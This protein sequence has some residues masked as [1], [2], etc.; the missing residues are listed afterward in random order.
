MKREAVQ[1]AVAAGNALKRQFGKNFWVKSKGKTD[2]VTKADKD[3]EKVYMKI[4]KKKFPSHNIVSEESKKINNKSDYTWYIDPL[5]GTGNYSA[6]LPF[7][8]TT[9][10]LAFKGELVLGV[11]YD[12][13]RNEM[14]IA[15]KGKGAKVNGRK[16]SV[17][18]EASMGKI[19]LGADSG[20]VNRKKTLIKMAN[21]VDSVRGE[22]LLGAASLALCYVA[23]GR[24]NAYVTGNT[25]NW[26][27]GAGVLMVEEA[28]GKVTDF[29]N[30][31]W[32]IDCKEVAAA[33]K[34]LHAKILRK[35]K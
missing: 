34:I 2:V 22:R 16:I 31:K 18:K 29:K 6:G 35:I 4:L 12:P 30:K 9:V 5:D 23:C 21:I 20:H 27:V 13:L 10:C 32:E 19:L 3:A 1:A 7:W 25:T 24:L 14:F 17:C 11:T 28:G 15:E 33:N 8:G 26:D